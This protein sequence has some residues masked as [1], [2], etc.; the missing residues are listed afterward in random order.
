[1]LKVKV[2]GY[3]NGTNKEIL[4]YITKVWG[5]FVYRYMDRQYLK[6][7]FRRSEYVVHKGYDTC[8]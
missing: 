8:R 5:L 3:I 6:E 2:D 1:M 4:K 7:D